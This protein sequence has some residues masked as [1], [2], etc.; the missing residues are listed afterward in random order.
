L[1]K[2]PIEKFHGIG[3]VTA[4]KMR[5]MNINSGFDLKQWTEMELIRRFGKVGRH[6][7]RIC[8]G[9]DQSPVNPNRIR[10]SI[11]AEETFWDDLDNEDD[12]KAELVPIAQKVFDYMKSKDNFGR[13]LT[14]KAKN[15]DFVSFTRSKTY[16]S[17]LRDFDELLKGVF[18]LLSAHKAQ[19]G[20]VRLLGVGVSNLS[21]DQ[22]V[23]G[24]QLEI[25]FFEL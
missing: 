17:E 18:E 4:A 12:M 15:T 25:D 21:R 11:S 5:K 10:K 20:K 8:R 3:K 2:L 24:I 22:V 13:T 16:L 19:F 6:Y 23:D 7:F 1:E 14:L 9:E